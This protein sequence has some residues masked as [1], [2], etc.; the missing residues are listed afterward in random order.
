MASELGESEPEEGG[1]VEGG[2]VG[3]QE[4]VSLLS[5]AL[6][7]ACRALLSGRGGGVC[8]EGRQAG[9]RDCLSSER[10]ETAFILL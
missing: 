1:L 8:V 6:S 4:P 5:P 10:T 3:Q 7:W 9:G 2:G